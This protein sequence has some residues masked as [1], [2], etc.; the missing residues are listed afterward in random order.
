LILAFRR[1][2]IHR[3]SERT[4]GFHWVSTQGR[5]EMLSYKLR[6]PLEKCGENLFRSKLHQY[7]F[8]SASECRHRDTLDSKLWRDL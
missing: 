1:S 2:W 3:S 6:L 4:S 8:A 5:S 7:P